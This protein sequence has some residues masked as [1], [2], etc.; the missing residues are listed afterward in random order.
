MVETNGTSSMSK[1]LL[2]FLGFLILF[3]AA[4]AGIGYFFPDFEE[5]KS[6]GLI[7]L[8][9]SAM[10][11]GQ[12]FVRDSG[13]ALTSGEKLKF[14]VLGTIISLALSIGLAW[15]TFAYFGIPFTPST[16]YLALIGQNPSPGD[17]QMFVLVGGGVAI[18][19]SILICYFAA[20]FGAK[21]Q[22]KQM[23]KLAAKGK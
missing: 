11:S 10:S 22:L 19:A 4:L 16:V 21:T 17:L 6:M 9:V 1:M 20:G 23:A 13:R 15:A 18:I 5:P 2:A 12:I 3:Q 7:I 14:A 8:M